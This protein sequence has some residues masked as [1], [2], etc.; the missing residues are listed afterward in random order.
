MCDTIHL[1]REGRGIFM[2]DSKWTEY[3]FREFLI[4]F[5]GLFLI[6]AIVESNKFYVVLREPSEFFI[7]AFYYFSFYLLVLSIR[8]ISWLIKKYL[9]NTSSHD[10]VTPTSQKECSYLKAEKARISMGLTNI[11][12]Q[13]NKMSKKLRP[14]YAFHKIRSLF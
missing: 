1:R 2:W 8:T 5:M 7:L 12:L 11:T 13:V 3:M 9:K 10:H 14:L 6:L 4:L